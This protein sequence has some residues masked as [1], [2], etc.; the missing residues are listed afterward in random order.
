MTVD[1][2]ELAEYYA[3]ININIVDVVRVTVPPGRKCFGV[4]T[5]PFSGFVFPL[6]GRA[7]MFFDGV[8]YEMEYGK[9]FHAGPNMS[10]DKEVLGNSE[11]DFMVLHYQVGEQRN[12]MVS[13]GQAHFELET[14]GNTRINDLLHRLYK[15]CATSEPFLALRTKVLF[16]EM[17]SEILLS[18]DNRSRESGREMVE[19]AVAYMNM[20]Y[21][22][23]LTITQIAAQY[24]LNNKQFA[25]LFQRHTGIGPNEYLIQQR[26]ARARELLCTTRCSVAE[27]AACVG[28]ADPYYFSK[29]FKKRTGV[30]PSSF[31]KK[32]R[33]SIKI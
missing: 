8:P 9:I 5:P 22:E 7:R 10:L 18:A 17:M 27:I 25:Y 33:L 30:S 1:I 15:H 2:S 14:G 4:Y 3:K 12:D 20:Y 16:L 28:Y 11:W 32:K 29:L 24:G 13:Y 19:K 23:P 31:N 21:M 26:I 6:R